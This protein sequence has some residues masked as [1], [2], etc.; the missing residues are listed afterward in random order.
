ML[1][2]GMEAR[3]DRPLPK[4]RILARR[5]DEESDDILCLLEY[6]A[7]ETVAVP[8][9][10][11]NKLPELHPATPEQEAA[12]KHALARH[13]N[14]HPD[15][16]AIAAKIADHARAGLK[17]TEADVKKQHADETPHVDHFR[18]PVISHH[19]SQSVLHQRWFR[20]SELVAHKGDTNAA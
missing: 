10:D 6:P 4:G 8:K 12:H 19:E 18:H 9:L 1:K 16:A 13:G 5:I 7:T 17:L 15:T 3:V 14:S 20:E 11:T 2:K